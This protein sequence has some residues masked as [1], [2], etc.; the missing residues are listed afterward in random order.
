MVPKIAKVF[1]IVTI[2]LGLSGLVLGI[3]AL[4]MGSGLLGI[5]NIVLGLALMAVG[6]TLRGVLDAMGQMGQ[7]MASILKALNTPR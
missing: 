4:I 7:G 2:I 5:A 6:M 3:V 1:V